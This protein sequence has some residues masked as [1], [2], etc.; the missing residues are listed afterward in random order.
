MLYRFPLPSRRVRSIAGELGALALIWGGEVAGLEAYT[1]PVCAALI[2]GDG[3][4]RYRSGHAFTRLWL[5]FNGTALGFGMMALLLKDHMP[6]DIYG[7]LC[8]LVLAAIFIWGSSWR[9]PLVRQ[10]AEQREGTLLAA[11]GQEAR[12]DRFFR[13]YTRIW[14]LYFALRAL[15]L[16]LMSC[17]GREHTVQS[18]LLKLSLVVM[19]LISFRGKALYRLYASAGRLCFSR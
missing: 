19:I 4:R 13:I 7:A 1:L 16:A 11:P 9:V 5:T 6:A 8:A 18:L 2:A 15:A 3:F 14:G 10:L 12:L 17:E